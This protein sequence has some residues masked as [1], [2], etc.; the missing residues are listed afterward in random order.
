M[1][2]ALDRARDML[3][4]A[5]GRQ[6][7][8]WGVGKITGQLYAVLYLAEHPL[9]LEEAARALGVTKGN[10]SVSIRTL[11]QLGMVRRDWHAGD[12]RVF[13][14]AEADF[15]VIAQRLLERRQ[16]PEFDASFAMVEESLALLEEAPDAPDIRHARSRVQA[17]KAFYDELDA[18]VAAILAMEPRRLS[19]LTRV[20][21]RWT[22]RRHSD[23]TLSKRA[24]AR[25]QGRRETR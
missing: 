8:F 22:A 10:V 11:E 23:R 9:S 20:A 1:E 21:R 13:F 16:R 4:H 25:G 18:I 5:L 15:W 6:S 17:L 12:R 3:V 24:P 14:E 7:A 19:W 2:T